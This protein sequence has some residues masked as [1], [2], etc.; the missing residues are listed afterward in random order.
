MTTPFE[1]SYTL[2]LPLATDLDLRRKFTVINEPLEGNLRFGILLE[3]LDSVA[4][5]AALGY[6]NRFYPDARVVTAAL[7]NI[8][9]R[10]VA[11]VT[12]DFVCRARINQVGRSSMEVGIHVGQ[13]GT[14]PNHVAS[15]YFTMVARSG[16][17]DDAVSIELPSLDYRDAMEIKRAEKAL[18]RREDYRYQQELLS[19]PPDREELE[20][21]AALHGAQ[22]RQGFQGLLAAGLVADAWDRMYPEF[23]NVP[24]K[25]FGGLIMRRAYELSSICSELVAPNRP[26]IA[27][28]NRINFFHPVRI[29][30]KLHYTSRV[31]YT[32]GSYICVEANIERISRDRTTKALSNSCLFTF[33]NVDRDLAHQPVPQVYPS[34]YLEDARY[35]KAHRSFKA[36]AGFIH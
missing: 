12:K 11:D 6:V 24:Q 36:L 23:E 19:G 25:V 1:T 14:P 17:G 33:V 5:K 30:D 29:G 10:H 21:L 20:M 27:A 15:C 31:V 18:M 26:I 2:T 4:E 8:I 9:I 13:P 16:M 3:T 28:V 7:D 22:D 35:L 34:N 32:N